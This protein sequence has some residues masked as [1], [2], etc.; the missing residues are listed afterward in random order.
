MAEIIEGIYQ[1]L[2]PFPEFSY[3]DAKTLRRQLEEAKEGFEAARDAAESGAA[4]PA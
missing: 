1:L 4:V 3:D 2:T